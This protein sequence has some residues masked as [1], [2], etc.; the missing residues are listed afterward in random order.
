M[1]RGAGLERE[2]KKEGLK[3]SQQQDT[4]IRYLKQMLYEGKLEPGDRLPAERKLSEQLSVSRLHV[5]Q[6]L[7][8]L[9]S[10]GIVK[11][12][13][14]SGSVIAEM[15]VQ[16]L[17]KMITDILQ[18]DQ[19]DFHSLVEVRGLLET[20]AIRLCALNRDEE[21]LEAI[22]TT[23]IQCEK[24]FDD[25]ESRVDIDFQYHR[26][27]A[28]GS[29]NPVLASMLLIITPDILKYYRRYNTCANPQETVLKE[30]REM[31]RCIEE[32]DADGAAE[33]LSRHLRGIREFARDNK[34]RNMFVVEA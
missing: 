7:Q 3:K 31:F 29:H 27:I 22:R 33:V 34:N 18:I 9:E 17:E 21:D 2:M 19:Y 5:R 23:L 11:T 4:V 30:H 25:P 14:Q 10:Y 16:S 32:C 1:L 8:K 12:F 20:E 6:A 24:T 15:K 13:P 28:L 26:A